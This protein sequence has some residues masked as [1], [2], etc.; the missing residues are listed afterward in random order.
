MSLIAPTILETIWNVIT[1][2]AGFFVRNWHLTLALVGII[3]LFWLAFHFTHRPPKLN[4]Q[5]IQRA[6][7]AIAKQDH[8]EMVQVLAESDTAEKQIDANVAYARTQVEN[9]MNESKQTW[10]AKSNQELA[11]ELER[12]AQQP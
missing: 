11:E 6:Q 9:A 4:Q 8:D 10:S 2:I 7:T 3:V 12:R 1:G 5:Q